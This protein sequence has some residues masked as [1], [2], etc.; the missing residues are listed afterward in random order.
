[1]MHR[2]ALYCRQFSPVE[3][4]ALHLVKSSKPKNT[5]PI[6]LTYWNKKNALFF[7]SEREVSYLIQIHAPI[8]HF[9]GL[10][11]IMPCLDWPSLAARLVLAEDRYRK[12]WICIE[13]H[14]C[15]ED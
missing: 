7:L 9:L 2:L 13:Y 5:I 10:D 12:N 6:K 4:K 1:M 15:F 11:P 8:Q 3:C 14:T